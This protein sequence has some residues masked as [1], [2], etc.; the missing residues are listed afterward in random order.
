[1]GT[2]IVPVSQPQ[3]S[4]EGLLSM[5]RLT[6]PD[7]TPP[8]CTSKRDDERCMDPRPW[9]CTQRTPLSLKSRSMTSQGSRSRL[10]QNL[11]MIGSHGNALGA[12]MLLPSQC[13]GLS[14]RERRWKLEPSDPA[15][16]SRM[17]TWTR[18]LH[19]YSASSGSI[20]TSLFARGN[21][22]SWGSFLTGSSGKKD[23][24]ISWARTLGCVL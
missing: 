21:R 18:P 23:R 1:M 3:T 16:G 6:R 20:Q 15:A 22:V 8:G 19:R 10:A 9:I 17:L 2:R 4:E 24:M 12:R 11:S 5:D 13:S 7:G 14:S